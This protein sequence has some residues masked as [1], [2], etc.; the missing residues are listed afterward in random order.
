MPSLRKAPDVVKIAKDLGLAG[1]DPV[2]SI[3]NHCRERVAS[4]VAQF[5]GRLALSRFHQLIDDRLD[6]RHEVIRS[7]QQL[8]ELIAEQTARGETIFATLKDEFAG[9]TEAITVKLGKAGIGMKR[10]IAV[11]DGRGDRSRR[12]YFGKRHEGSHLLTMSPMQLSFVFRRTHAIRNVAEERLMDRISS[13]LAFYPPIFRPEVER[14]QRRYARPCFRLVDDLRDSICPEASWTATAI[15]M[16]EQNNFPA[17]LLTARY[18]T[19]IGGSGPA[20]PSWALRSTS[21]SNRAAN[22]AGLYIPWNYRVPV[23]SL[24]YRAFHESTWILDTEA[25]E[26]LGVW[27]ASNGSHLPD[28]PIHVELRKQIGQIAAIITLN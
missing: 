23:D 2:E 10:H 5:K 9:G 13:E 21:R 27:T 17:L 11:I 22:D 24:I 8:D 14:F 6:V 15:A 18:G 26:Y 28:L 12:V 7:D 19:K 3:L 4:W 16:I 1:S 25:D 20:S